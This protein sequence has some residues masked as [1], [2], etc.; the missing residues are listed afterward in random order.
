MENLEFKIML[1]NNY[2]TNPSSM[3]ICFP[4][5]IE[6]ATN[7]DADIDTDVIP[8]NNF[9]AHLIKKINITRYGNDK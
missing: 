8:V 9:F 5:K 6:K 1:T 4:M 3:Y 2:Y 7:E